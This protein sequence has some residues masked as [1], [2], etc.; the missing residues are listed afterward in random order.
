MTACPQK[1]EATSALIYIP[2]FAPAAGHVTGP[3]Y[4]A[5]LLDRP[6]NGV[7]KDPR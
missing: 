6:T 5:P 3:L 4:A 7:A 2:A 1:E